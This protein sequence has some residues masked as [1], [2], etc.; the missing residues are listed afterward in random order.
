MSIHLGNIP[1]R[2]RAAGHDHPDALY[3][4]SRV[5]GAFDDRLR[6]GD[7][8]PSSG[9][10]ILTAL[11]DCGTLR[12]ELWGRWFSRCLVSLT[13]ISSFLRVRGLC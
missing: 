12:S 11:P 5:H 13:L 3:R 6:V 1:G 4:N 2:G 9:A 7:G 10:A 8:A